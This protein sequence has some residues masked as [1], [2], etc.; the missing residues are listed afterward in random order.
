M[1]SLPGPICR[2]DTEAVR[3]WDCEQSQAHGQKLK[4]KQRCGFEILEKETA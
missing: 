4:I 1:D 2:G 3:H